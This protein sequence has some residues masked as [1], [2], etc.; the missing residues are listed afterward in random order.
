MLRYNYLCEKLSIMEIWKRIEGFKPIYEVSNKGRIRSLARQT[1]DNGGI[2]NRKE[3][4]LK[5]GHMR[6][7]LCV[8]LYSQEGKRISSLVHRIVAK[9]FIPNLENK[10]EIDHIDGDK[11][12]NT[13]ANLRW[14]THKENCA[15]PITSERHKQYVC[16]KA[17]HKKAIAAYSLQGK[18]IGIWPTIT[19]A[20]EATKTCRH[21]ISSAAK[22]KYKM[23][24]DLIWK[25]YGES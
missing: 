9:A 17:P 13:V 6:G 7:Y 20:S 15:N 10:P 8:Y 11:T 21:S 12:N 25:Y 5:F 18:L 16:E 22:G 3:R 1:N 14:V 19:M 2:F 4:I 24:N 23:A